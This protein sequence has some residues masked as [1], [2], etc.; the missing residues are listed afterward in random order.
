MSELT[1]VLNLVSSMFTLHFGAEYLGY[2][3]SLMFGKTQLPSMAAV[4]Q[5]PYQCVELICSEVANLLC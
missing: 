1:Q 4:L 5:W 2:T 3:Y